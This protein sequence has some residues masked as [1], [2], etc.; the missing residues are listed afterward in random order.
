MDHFNPMAEAEIA[1]LDEEIASAREAKAKV[2]S[3]EEQP[4]P[5]PQTP[6]LNME[7]S[8]QPAEVKDE[9]KERRARVFQKEEPVEYV[10]PKGFWNWIKGY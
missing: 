5:S 7:L 6:T 3:K 10:K 8:E 9:A 1:L 4:K 2:E